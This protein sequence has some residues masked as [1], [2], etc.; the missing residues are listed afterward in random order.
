MA[1]FWTRFEVKPD[2]I[3]VIVYDYEEN[4]DVEVKWEVISQEPDYDGHST[5]I[6]IKYLNATMQ[7]GEIAIGVKFLKRPGCF[8]ALENQVKVH[9]A[10]TITINSDHNDNEDEEGL[11]PAIEIISD[12]TQYAIAAGLIAGSIVGAQGGLFPAYHTLQ[13]IAYLS[14]MNLD[15]P[16]NTRTYMESSLNFIITPNIFD[17]KGHTGARRLEMKRGKSYLEVGRGTF[18]VNVGKLLT[19]G[20]IMLVLYPIGV[21]FNRIRTRPTQRMGGWITNGYKYNFFVRFFIC[22]YMIIGF[23][24]FNQAL[25]PNFSTWYYTTSTIIAY[26]FVVSPR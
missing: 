11:P 13:T 14:V 20:L 21:I 10:K 7:E 15:I 5:E 6:Q 19:I 18:L 12:S 1:I 8:T 3:E 26:I 4:R 17:N 16:A 23:S 25:Y 9:I 22:N 24:A 2:E